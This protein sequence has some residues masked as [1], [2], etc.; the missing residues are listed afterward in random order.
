MDIFIDIQGFLD[1]NDKFLPKEVA[2][3]AS[4][5]EF[6]GH[7]IVKPT[8][9]FQGLPDEVKRKNNWLTINHHGIEWFEGETS[10]NALNHFLQTIVPICVNI[11]TRGQDKRKYLQMITSREIIDLEKDPHCPTFAKMKSRKNT[12]CH[13]HVIKKSKSCNQLSCALDNVYKLRSWVKKKS[14]PDA[15]ESHDTVDS[16]L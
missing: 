9:Y 10:I 8:C 1:N 2:V 16:L 11:Y 3:L 12:M 6:I 13:V 15:L 7:W 14:E 4:K 5:N